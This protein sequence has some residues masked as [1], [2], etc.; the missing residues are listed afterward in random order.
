[1]HT[2]QPMPID[3]LEFDPFTMIA[4]D[5]MAISAGTPEKAN[6]MTAS[7]GGVGE[8]WGKDVVYI[9]VR[10]SRYTKEFLDKEDGF[11]ITFFDKKEHRTLK[12]F[13]SVS[14]RNEDKMANARMHFNFFNDIPYIDEG[15][16][17]FCC[18]KLAAVPITEDQFVDTEIKPKWYEKGDFHTMYV[19]EILQVM[20]R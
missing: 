16:L 11:S 12:Y 18:K 6:T 4:Q 20:A 5:W 9:F 2:F 17:V 19:G 3:M 14:G 13:G 7:W 15:N 10:D 8:L 1:M